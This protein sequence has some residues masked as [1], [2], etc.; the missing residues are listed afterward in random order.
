M[1]N[2][3]TQGNKITKTTKL[4]YYCEISTPKMACED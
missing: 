4:F 2:F 1:S 3:G